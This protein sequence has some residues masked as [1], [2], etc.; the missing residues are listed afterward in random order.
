M[1]RNAAL[2][3]QSHIT[4]DFLLPRL[5]PQS[6]TISTSFRAAYEDVIPAKIVD[7]LTSPEVVDALNKI[8]SLPNAVHSLS[9]SDAQYFN[10]LITRLRTALV[11]EE[12]ELAYRYWVE[13]SQKGLLRLLGPAH[14]DMCSRYLGGHIEDIALHVAVGGYP[15][16]LKEYLIFRL[17]QNN[18][19][20]VH[21]VYAEY[22]S[23]V[24]AQTELQEASGEDVAEEIDLSQASPP[25]NTDGES[26]HLPSSDSSRE[27]ND[28]FHLP[29]VHID[30]LCPKIAACAMQ[31]RFRDALTTVLQTRVRLMPNAT[32][33]FAARF[34][35]RQDIRR[36]FSEYIPRLELGRLLSRPRSL[37]NQLF[38]LARTNADKS[39]ER[40]YAQMKTALLETDP[41]VVAKPQPLDDKI[42][43]VVPHFA[44][45]SFLSAFLKCR[46][47]ELAE[48]LWDD[49]AKFKVKP[50]L[51]TWNSLLE[52]YAEA[53]P[54]IAERVSS[55]WKAMTSQGIKPDTQSY[56]A[57]IHGLFYSRFTREAMK[58]FDDFQTFVAVSR[59][60]DEY[61]IVRVYNTTLHGLLINNMETEA[62]TILQQMQDEGPPPDIVS[63]NT[64]MRY[65]ERLGNTKEIANILRQ[66]DSL[67]LA[68]DVFTFSTLLRALLKVR[69]DAVDVVFN[70]MDR[71]GVKANTALYTGLIDH[72]LKQPDI[73][74]LKTALTLLT[75]M[76]QSDDKDLAPNEITYTNFIARI[77]QADW[78]D[79]ATVDEYHRDIT[80]RMKDRNIAPTR[81]MYNIL[82]KASLSNPSYEG[83]QYAL[84]YFREMVDRKIG[85]GHD[86]WWIMLQGLARRK[87]W[88]LASQMAEEMDRSGFKPTVPLINLVNRIKAMWVQE[89]STS[90]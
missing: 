83:L 23:K 68:G 77:L 81:P 3:I 22:F 16:A 84:M 48:T 30:I 7:Q 82:L 85:V 39:L 90:R 18:P 80:Q 19:D 54:N 25:H 69:Q 24:Q 15:N 88:G 57:L 58:R 26:E 64:F 89:N 31:D 67:G 37:T 12:V 51:H 21:R 75:R 72:I 40:L 45:G 62:L 55:A 46:Q 6:R 27:L 5:A 43:V 49:L 36:K 65:Y 44:W 73:T 61:G 8:P 87:E 13:L 71:Q 60:L 41:W 74:V 38:N 47:L 70:L 78:L 1:L 2:R 66:I 20:V 35:G 79:V 32:H 53:S 4:L 9:E 50:D 52:G 28:T 42:L 63:F 34:R 76:E 10:K 86:V 29:M 33:L 59:D 17:K 14:L 11:N 56:R